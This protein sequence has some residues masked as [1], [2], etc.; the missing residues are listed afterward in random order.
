MDVSPFHHFILLF[1]F[2]A[3]EY[4]HVP[5]TLDTINV[6][7]GNNCPVSL[8]KPFPVKITEKGASSLVVGIEKNALIADKVS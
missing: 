6:K 8:T 4:I 2:Q 3:S 5:V 1:V 7:T